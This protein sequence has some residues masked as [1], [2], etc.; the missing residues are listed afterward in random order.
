M[1]SQSNNNIATFDP[2]IH[3]APK[4][5][6]FMATYW[7][8]ILDSDGRCIHGPEALVW[9]PG[10]KYWCRLGDEASGYGGQILKNKAAILC[11][12]FR[13]DIEN[14]KEMLLD[15]RKLATKVHRKLYSG[16]TLDADDKEIIRQM[17]IFLG[18]PI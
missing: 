5:I 4:N 9:Q 16:E 10:A 11:E 6:R 15:I 3:L 12:V 17:C 14:N 8:E 18:N 2:N 1:F 7:V 13:P